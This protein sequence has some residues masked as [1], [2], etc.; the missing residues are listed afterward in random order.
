MMLVCLMGN[1]IFDHIDLR[2]PNLKD[3]V[4][5]YQ[6]LLPA[7]GFTRKVDVDGWLQYETSDGDINPFFW[8]HRV[9]EPRAK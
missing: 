2:V 3:A 1:R 8:H 7:L 5:F 9:G 4:S 6:S